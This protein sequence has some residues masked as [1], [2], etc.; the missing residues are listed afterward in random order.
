MSILK[1]LKIESDV[2]QSL[3]ILMEQNFILKEEDY[4]N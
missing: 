3:K 4:Q 1:D 2:Y